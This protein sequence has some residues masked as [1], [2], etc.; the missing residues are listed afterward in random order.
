MSK[1]T[2]DVVAALIEKDEKFLVARRC[3]DDSF[4]GMWEFPGGV[5]EPGETKADALRR[6][7]REELGVDIEVMDIAGIFEDE[8]PTLKIVIYLFDCKIKD[9]VPRPIECDDV[10]WA[11]TEE[12]DGIEL[13]PADRKV[14]TWLKKRKRSG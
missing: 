8:I 3:K 11:S 4:G 6:E 9:G 7:I 5:V 1:I 2:K 14:L 12:M 10:N 13:A